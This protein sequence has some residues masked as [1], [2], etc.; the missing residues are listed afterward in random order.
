MAKSRRNKEV[1]LT[2]VKKHS[3]EKKNKL[4][5]SIRSAI[6]SPENGKD[7]FVYLLALSNQ[8]NSPL[9]NL[10][11]ILKPGRVFYGKNKVM[12]LALGQKPESELVTNIHKIAERISGERALLVSSE[13][14]DVVKGKLEG[15][16]VADFSKS[17]NVAVDT[18]ILKPDD[19]ILKSFPGNMEPQLRQLGLPTI[20]N[21]GKIKLLSEFIVCEK[22]KP[23]TPNQAQILKLIGIRMSLFEVNVAAYWH[24][25]TFFDVKG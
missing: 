19:E 17:G 10:R 25:G 18:V 23:L 20:L 16:K 22:G 6:E 2:A 9:K 8:R 4:V 1:R 7:C 14:P 21:L 5:E 3:K 11:I 13:T 12:Q 24:D 15:Y